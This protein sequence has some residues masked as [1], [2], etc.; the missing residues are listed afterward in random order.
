M[1]KKNIF[2]LLFLLSALASKAQDA[3]AAPQMADA[4]RDNG[5]IYVV[6]TVIALI[7]IAI[8]CFLVYLER[9]LKKLEQQVKNK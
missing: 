7:F 6:I 5:K 2:S 3:T 8:V 9:K 4:I 1:I